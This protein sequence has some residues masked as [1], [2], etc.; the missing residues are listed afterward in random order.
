MKNKKKKIEAEEAF[1]EFV[2]NLGLPIQPQDARKLKDLKSGN[3][4]R[5]KPKG[6]R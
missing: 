6:K 2:E 5:A 3:R 4:K 1:H